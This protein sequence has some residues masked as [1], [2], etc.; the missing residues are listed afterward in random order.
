MYSLAA[1]EISFS[2]ARGVTN[3]LY[4]N[5]TERF[6]MD[7]PAINIHR[8]RDHGLQPYYKYAELYLSKAHG[9]NVRLRSFNDVKKYWRRACFEELPDLYRLVS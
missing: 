4:R 7:L 1:K 3:Y 2:F 8:G 6:G 9:T 5:A